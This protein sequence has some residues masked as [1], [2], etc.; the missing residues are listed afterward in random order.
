MR[1]LLALLKLD[2]PPTDEGATQILNTIPDF[3]LL[4]ES[5]KV[6]EISEKE[7]KRLYKEEKFCVEG[8]K[9]RKK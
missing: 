6:Q 8:T 7:S 5:A 4:Y 2:K 3:E 9:L 1:S